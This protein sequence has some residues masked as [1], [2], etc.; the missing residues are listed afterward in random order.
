[1]LPFTLTMPGYMHLEGVQM[2]YGRK[3]Q[4]SLFWPVRGTGNGILP[5][6]GTDGCFDESGRE[7]PCLGSRQDREL[8]LG[9][10]WP[11]PRFVITDVLVTNKLTDLLPHNDI[12]QFVDIIFLNGEMCL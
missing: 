5:A 8:Q 1:M 6:T 2:L 3:E 12:V 7:I 4:Y 10:P 9:S 11:Q